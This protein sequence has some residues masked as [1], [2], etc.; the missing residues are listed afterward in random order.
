MALT[1]RIYVSMP[2]DQWLTPPQK[3]LRAGLVE[4][5]RQAGYV[6]EIFADPTGGE[7]LAA[8]KAWTADDAEEIARHCQGAA[9]IGLPRWD[10]Q[11][12]DGPVRLP[13]E[14]CQYEGALARTLSLPLL[15]V[16]QENL[17]Q[18]GVFDPNFGPYVAKFPDGADRSWLDT[19]GFKVAFAYWRRKLEERRDL[20]LGYS[21]T[22]SEIASKVRRFLEKDVGANVLDWQRDFR[23]GRSILEEIEEARLRCT[24]GIFLFTRDD[25]LMDAGPGREAAPR[26]NVVFEAGYFAAAKGKSRV[27]IIREEATKMPADLGGDIYVPLDRANLKPVA[28]ELRRFVA[29]F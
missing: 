25:G 6:P 16:V 7:S 15:V 17:M 19:D 13:T 18:R 2:A 21:G 8:S 22:S 1:R 27:L 23:P 3:D 26:D 20:F 29:T 28:K 12:A 5:I 14:F 11:T 24:A 4:R 9:L 10:F